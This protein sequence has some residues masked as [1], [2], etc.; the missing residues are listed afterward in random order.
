MNL[1][2]VYLKLLKAHA[3]RKL[4][5]AEK[6]FAKVLQAQVEEGYER[7]NNKHSTTAEVDKRQ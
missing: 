3:R 1:K 4:N 6:L 7:R 5:K 2:K